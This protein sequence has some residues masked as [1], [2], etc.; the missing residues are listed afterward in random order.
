MLD[1]G[2]QCISISAM[3]IATSEGVRDANVHWWTFLLT[4]HMIFESRIPIILV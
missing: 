2:E 3:G 1:I 4:D